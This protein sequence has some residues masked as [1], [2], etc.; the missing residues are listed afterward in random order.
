[1][2]WGWILRMMGN[3]SAGPSAGSRT[4]TEIGHTPKEGSPKCSVRSLENSILPKAT[5]ACPAFLEDVTGATLQR[6]PNMPTVGLTYQVAELYSG[7]R[8]LQGGPQTPEKV[9]CQGVPRE[10]GWEEEVRSRAH[11]TL[12]GFQPG[13]PSLQNIHGSASS[14]IPVQT[15]TLSDSLWCGLLPLP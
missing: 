10:R 9:R 3:S 7:H 11:F 1:L 4:G 12:P 15:E 13:L 5:R 14:L 6:P 2:R 8:S